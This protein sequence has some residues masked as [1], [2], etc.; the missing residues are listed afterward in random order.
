MMQRRAPSATS[1]LLQKANSQLKGERIKKPED[2]LDVSE[3]RYEETFFCTNMKINIY[4][5]IILC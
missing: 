2:E 1:A 4:G 5:I 3:Q